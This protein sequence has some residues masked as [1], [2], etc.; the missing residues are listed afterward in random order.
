MRW[1]NLNEQG[2][3]GFAAFI[4]MFLVYVTVTIV[5]IEIIRVE[6][7]PEE[8]VAEVVDEELEPFIPETPLAEG[9]VL[10]FS[11][12]GQE[13]VLLT[14][15]DTSL[16]PENTPNQFRTLLSNTLPASSEVNQFGCVT[17][18]RIYKISNFNVAGAIGSAD[19]NTRQATEKCSK[20]LS[21]IWYLDET[22]WS[23]LTENFNSQPFCEDLNNLPI[24]NEFVSECVRFEDR[25][26]IANPNGTIKNWPN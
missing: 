2:G 19:P 6:P 3:I 10:D 22:S 18:Y 5:Y 20:G 14:R 9:Q 21:V 8:P 4:V 12:P 16:L 24:Y 13:I 23:W 1:R 7:V 17:A 15:D 25:E 26:I 11:G